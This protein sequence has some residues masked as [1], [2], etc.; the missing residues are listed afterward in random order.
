MISHRPTLRSSHYKITYRNTD[1]HA[2]PAL[3]AIWSIGKRPAAAKSDPHEIAINVLVNEM[4]GGGYLRA[5]R[6]IGE[7][8][9]WIGRRRVKLQRS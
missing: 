8:T 2:S 4:A 3:V 5:G 7:I 1:W 9:A 6:P